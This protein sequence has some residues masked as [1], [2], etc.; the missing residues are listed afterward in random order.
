[1]QQVGVGSNHLRAQRPCPYYL[2]ELTRSGRPAARKVPVSE[3]LPYLDAKVIGVQAIRRII[4]EQVFF[5]LPSAIRRDWKT[6]RAQIGPDGAP[7][8]TAAAQ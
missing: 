2:D 1:V 6:Q 4:P 7:G 8:P 3:G 5:T